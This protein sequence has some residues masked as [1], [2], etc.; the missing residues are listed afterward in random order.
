[1]GGLR[2]TEPY[3]WGA[4][5]AKYYSVFRITLQNHLA[6]V[7]DFFM[8]TIFLIIILFVFT[9]LWETTYSVSGKQVLAGF[10]LEKLMWYLAATESIIMAMPRVVDKVEQ[11]VKNGDVAYFLNRPLSYIGF[12]YCAFLAESLI[13]FFINMLVGGALITLLFGPLQVSWLTIIGFIILLL[14]AFTLN[15]VVTMGLSLASFWIED[16]RGFDLVYSRLV[17]I[18]G[19][20]MVPLNLFPGWLESVAKALPFQKIIYTPAM[21]LVRPELAG[22]WG[23]F[24]G[25][26]GWILVFSLLAWGIFRMGVKKLNVNGG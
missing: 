14:G 4:K 5:I 22:G 9:Q 25:Q 21:Q 18:L 1:M 2:T 7:M 24:L 17:M 8:R 19:G 20:M 12:H 15:F 23:A 10:S 13:R 26:W 16:V 11:E 3:N 6:Y